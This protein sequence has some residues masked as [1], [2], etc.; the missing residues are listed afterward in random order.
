M[1][2]TSVKSTGCNRFVKMLDLT[3]TLRD[4]VSCK[5]KVCCFFAD[6]N[7]AVTVLNHIKQSYSIVNVSVSSQFL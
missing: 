4:N 1:G 7:V 5:V 3:G 2:M 6:K